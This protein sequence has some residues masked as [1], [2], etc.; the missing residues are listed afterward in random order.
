MIMEKEVSM[1]RYLTIAR[2]TEHQT[3]AHPPPMPEK[4]LISSVARA[5][6]AV[7]VS[8]MKLIEPV[9]PAFDAPA[10]AVLQLLVQSD[11]PLPHQ[12]IVRRMKAAGHDKTTAK[13]AI[14]RCQK[15]HWIEHNLETGYIL[16]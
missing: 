13:Q 1:G 8:P 10:S 12:E 4:N 16:S 7:L 2:D 5:T 15:R 11:R 3:P 9:K 14:A 6:L